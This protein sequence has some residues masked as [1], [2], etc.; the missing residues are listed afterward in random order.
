MGSTTDL[1]QSTGHPFYERLNRI[2]EARRLR[3]VRRRT[4]RAVLR[5]VGRPSLSPGRYF[6]LLLIAYSRTDIGLGAGH[7]VARG[8]FAEP[9]GVSAFGD[10]G[11]AARPFDDLADAA[12]VFG[13]DSSGG[14]HVGVAAVGGDGLGRGEDVGHRCDDAGSHAAMRSIVRRDT[15][16]DYTAF[17][18]GL[19]KASGIETPRRRTWRGLTGSGRRRRR[20]RSGLT[21]TTR[22]R[23][24]QR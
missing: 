20:T 14:L 24:S 11:G 8:R 1:P 3:R 9:A 4:V 22:M 23:K 7:R 10:T 13:R 2:L 21:L 6:R 15:G 19:A 5:D 12:P 18:T 17:L 16:E